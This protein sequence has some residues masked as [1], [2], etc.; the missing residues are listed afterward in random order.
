[1]RTHKCHWSVK[2]ISVLPDSLSSDYSVKDSMCYLYSG[3]LVH[4]VPHRKLQLTY[5]KISKH[6]GCY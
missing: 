1:M 4:V 6:Q 3:A 2:H 5:I